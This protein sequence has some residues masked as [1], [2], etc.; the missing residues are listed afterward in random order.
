MQDCPMAANTP[1]SMKEQPARGEPTVPYRTGQDQHREPSRQIRLALV[2][3][4]G[5]QPIGEIQR[6]LRKR[7]RIILVLVLA[8]YTI[9]IVRS[10][11]G[12]LQWVAAPP[13]EWSS[14]G[15]YGLIEAIAAVL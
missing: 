8:F 10:V 3:E 11:L 15:F 9:Q 13:V 2:P 1:N 5:P 12:L 6:L 4:A 14:L 7:L